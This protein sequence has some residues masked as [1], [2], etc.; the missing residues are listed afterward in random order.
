M[1]IHNNCPPRENKEI[2]LAKGGAIT[3]TIRVDL[4]ILTYKSGLHNNCVEDFIQECGKQIQSKNDINVTDCSYI[5]S[6][7]RNST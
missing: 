5:S 7:S 6:L 1:K 3:R 2:F 4:G